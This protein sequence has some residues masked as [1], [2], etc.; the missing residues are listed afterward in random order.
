ME[1]KLEDDIPL[2]ETNYGP[3]AVSPFR[4]LAREAK[5]GQSCVMPEKYRSDIHAR[6]RVEGKRIV[7]R[8]IGD[9][10]IRVWFFDNTRTKRVNL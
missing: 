3:V 1:F 6:A 2:P 10:M 7:T 9:G 8:T 4:R 5:D